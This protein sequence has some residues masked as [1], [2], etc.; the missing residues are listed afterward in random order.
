MH[1][2]HQVG[3]GGVDDPVSYPNIFNMLLRALTALI[4]NINR[5]IARKTLIE[6]HSLKSGQIKVIELLIIRDVDARAAISLR[7]HMPSWNAELL[8]LADDLCGD[9]ERREMN[10][11]A[12][13]SAVDRIAPRQFHQR[14]AEPRS[15][16]KASPPTAQRPSHDVGLEREKRRADIRQISQPGR[17][18]NALLA[19]QKI[20]IRPIRLHAD[21]PSIQAA[22]SRSV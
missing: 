10:Y 5:R 16:E 7:L 9:G 21:L 17:R 8:G 2:R 15:G 4:H 13:C 19:R 14:F 3:A 20:G 6:D 1:V 18:V 12:A 22:P 11:I